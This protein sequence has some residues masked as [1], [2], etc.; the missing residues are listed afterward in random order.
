MKL[1]KQQLRYIIK[2]ELTPAEKGVQGA[3]EENYHS[4]LNPTHPNMG[5]H[6]AINKAI[7]NL[8]NVFVRVNVRQGADELYAETLAE[9]LIEG[10][11]TLIDELNEEFDEV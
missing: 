7:E 8:A 2:E 6:V 1:T 9:R 4:R 3:K 10:V 5:L 11:E